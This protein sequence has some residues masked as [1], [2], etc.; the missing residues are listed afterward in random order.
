M[1]NTERTPS[2]CPVRVTL[3]Q[4]PTTSAYRSAHG[5]HLCLPS[6]LTSSPHPW[7]HTTAV[8]TVQTPPFLTGVQLLRLRFSLSVRYRGSRLKRLE[9]R[10]VRSSGLENPSKVVPCRGWPLGCGPSPANHALVLLQTPCMGALPPPRRER[11][12]GWMG[13]ACPWGLLPLPRHSVPH[14]ICTACHSLEVCRGSGLH[15]EGVV[16]GRE[17]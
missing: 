5:E 16:V 3:T 4:V 13:A 9:G 17:F 6:A 14:I 11:W 7:R 1:Q 2:K 10:S 15:G 12:G 8:E